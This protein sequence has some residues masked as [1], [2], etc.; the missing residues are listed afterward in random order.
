MKRL[1][2]TLLVV[3]L[4]LCH[5]GAQ[6]PMVLL[7]NTHFSDGTTVA[8][9]LSGT[10]NVSVDWG[11]G[12]TDDF[13]TEGLQ[14]HIYES[15]GRYTVSITGNLTRFGSNTENP[16]AGKLKKVISFGNLGLTSLANAFHKATQLEH[17]PSTLPPT[18]TN[19]SGIFNGAVSF[20]G[21]ISSWNVSNVTN[22]DR[23]F[24]NAVKFNQDIGG[25]DVSKVT[26]MVFMFIGAKAFNKDIGMWDVSKVNN[27]MSMFR[28]AS[29]FNQDIGSWDVSK[30]TNMTEMFRNASAFDQDIGSWDVSR[31][32]A[33]GLMFFNVKLSTAM[34]YQTEASGQTSTAM[35]CKAK[36][37]NNYSF[38]INLDNSQG[39]EVAANT[40]QISGSTS[41]GG[42]VAWTNYSDKRLKKE[43]QY[44]NTE[45]NL[46]K[47]LRL[48][49]VRFRWKDNNKLLNLGL[50]A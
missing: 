19:L 31:V 24:Y 48:N 14:E 12:S 26:S 27:M 10:V 29:A 39:P 41:I 7:Y 20:N 44:L 32:S 45:D 30:V 37:K 36:A 15:H 11:D 42:N 38:A 47:I 4:G 22:M 6:E 34:G 13:T 8:L 25:W 3:L 16:Y 35:G 43:I 49:A 33:M 50:L 9:P 1:H 2:L 5:V 21:D 18:V 23:M 17:V 46:S 28:D 40:F